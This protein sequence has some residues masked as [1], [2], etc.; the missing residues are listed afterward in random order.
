MKTKNLFLLFMLVLVPAFFLSAQEEPAEENTNSFSADDT[1]YI[2]EEIEFDVDGRSRPFALMYHGEFREGE[3]IW[4]KENLEKYLANK[5]QLLLNQ[6]VLEEVTIEYFTGEENE[7]GAIPVRL[8]V[9]IKDSRNFVVLPYPKYDSNEG[10]SITLKA[11]DYNFLGTMSTLGLDLGY[12]QKGSDE[13]VFSFSFDSDTPFNVFGL[14][15]NFNFD[16]KISYNLGDPLYYQNITGLSV[17]LPWHRTVFKVGFNHYLTINEEVTD[18]TK[19]LYD[20]EESFYNPY[21]SLEFYTAWQIPLG[22]SVADFG[23]LLYTP[24]I[25]QMFNYPTSGLDEPRKPVLS[26]SHK[27]SFGRTDWLGNLRKEVSAYLGNSYSWYFARSDAPLQI[28]L[29]AGSTVHWP[30]SKYF[31]ISSRL[32]YQQWWQW[33]S[34]NDEWIPYYYAGDKIRGV[35]DKYLRSDAILSLN[36]DLP[37][38]IVRFWPSELFDKPRLKFFDIEIYFSPF[39]DLALLQG[40]FL[41]EK[42][43]EYREIDFT[44]NDMISTTGF[45]II[46]Y[47]GYFRSLKLRGSIGY[48][49]KQT[50]KRGTPL[51]WGF[52]PDWDEIYVGLDLFY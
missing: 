48:D 13:K 21:A 3:K 42:T 18:E 51:K 45:E 6:R 14:N 23:E 41:N 5:T 44:F 31:S 29:S 52:F 33:S 30:F 36:L 10:Y 2:I 9:R 39:L 49:L 4:G 7:L 50:R 24:K 35:I 40:S 43:L 46:V 25:T 28:T 47:S 32:N 20:V 19:D 37:I 17:E 12:R 16:H 15:W 38:R 22:V 27:I 8:L 1:F 34:R 26:F 11:R